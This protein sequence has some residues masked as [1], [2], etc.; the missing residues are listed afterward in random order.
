MRTATRISGN[1][2]PSNSARD[3]IPAK[4]SARF[5]WM[6][7]D[8]AF[9]GRYV[10]DLCLLRKTTVQ[11]VAHEPV[12]AREEGGQGLTRPCRRGDQRVSPFSYRG[13]PQ[14]LSLGRRVEL[15][16]KPRLNK[17]MKRR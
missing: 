17:G 7:L 8:R 12:Q 1:G 6:S 4:G 13:P 11:A 10:Y 14:G 9:R 2:D 5:R 15:S 16:A 3:L